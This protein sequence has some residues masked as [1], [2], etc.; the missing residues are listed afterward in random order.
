MF[1][2][3]Y[4]INLYPDLK[5]E[6]GSKPDW[7]LQVSKH[8]R[9]TG[10]Q[11]GRSPNPLFVPDFYLE[12]YPDLKKAFG[13]TNYFG[14]LHHWL[15]FGVKEGRSASPLFDPLAYKS[16]NADV[17]KRFR[18]NYAGLAQHY[19]QKG[20]SEGRD[21]K[22]DIEKVRSVQTEG[23]IQVEFL[24]VTNVPSGLDLETSVKSGERKLLRIDFYDPA[25]RPLSRSIPPPT[26]SD[27]AALEELEQDRQKLRKDKIDSGEWKALDLD[28]QNEI[29]NDQ[30][31][32]EKSRSKP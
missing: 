4:Y 25:T 21:G 9:E 10:S 18:Q 15:K 8:Y 1:S 31:S 7:V 11:E 6:F 12:R 32:S 30:T 14:V 16:K 24:S 20:V 28:R 13:P 3:G 2:P 29:L 17:A 22:A 19:L 23:K 5:E 27:A 26:S